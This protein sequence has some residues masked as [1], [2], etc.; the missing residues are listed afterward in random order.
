MHYFVVAI[1]CSAGSIFLGVNDPLLLPRGLLNVFSQFRR[2]TG[3]RA[4]EMFVIAFSNVDFTRE[5]Y[6]ACS[7]CTNS[8]CVCFFFIITANDGF[9]RR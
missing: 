8:V 5:K 3:Q 2:E 1:L 6:V 7:Y 4:K 9:L